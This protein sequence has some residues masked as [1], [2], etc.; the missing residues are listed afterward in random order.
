M[1]KRMI[2]VNRHLFERLE[3]YLPSDSETVSQLKIGPTSIRCIDTVK[4]SYAQE[5]IKE[6]IFLETVITFDKS[7]LLTFSFDRKIYLVITSNTQSIPTFIKGIDP[8]VDLDNID[9]DFKNN[10]GLLTILFSNDNF[11]TIIDNDK[12]YK[13]LESIFSDEKEGLLNGRFNSSE[14][15]EFFSDFSVW[16]VGEKFKPINK[17]TLLSIYSAYLIESKKNITLNFSEQSGQ[18]IKLIIEDLPM[19]LIGGNIYRSLTAMDWKHSFLELYQCIEYLFPVP[20]LLTLA[21]NVGDHSL[22]QKL[23]INTENDLGWR[24]KENE[25]LS[26]LLKRIESKTSFVEILDSFSKILKHNPS[27]PENNI[28]FVS[29]HIYK[30]R[31]SIAHF[32]SALSNSVTTDDEWRDIVEKTSNIIYDLYIE[33][34]TEISAIK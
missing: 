18:N 25:A 26:I 20:Y 2:D 10:P 14:L 9:Q 21:K 34:S 11:P 29:K 19:D 8:V 17:N 24:P 33:F 5:I 7:V 1:A 4:N 13:L 31:N 23:F 22:L 6:S 12:R 27:N 30:T 3:C 28:P 32:R 16:E 15:V